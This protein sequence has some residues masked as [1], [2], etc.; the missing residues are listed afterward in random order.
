M[1]KLNVPRRRSVWLRRHAVW[2]FATLALCVGANAN[3]P[4]AATGESAI[5]GKSSRSY[6]QYPTPP[7]TGPSLPAPPIKA[8]KPA[9]P[10]RG[11]CPT[12]S[13][14]A[15][16]NYPTGI[17]PYG[18]VLGHFNADGILDLAVANQ[19]SGTVSIRLG[20]GGGGFGAPASFATEWAP[21]GLVADDFNEDGY[22]DLAT[23]CQ[24][25]ASVSVLFGDGAGGFGSS[26]ILPSGNDPNWITSGDFDNDANVDIAVVVYTGY[27]VVYLGNGAGGFGYA[28][29]YTAGSGA[30][31]LL[32]ADFS[33]DGNLDIVVGNYYASDTVT[34]LPGNGDGT[35]DPPVAFSTGARTSEVAAGFFDADANLDAAVANY[36][37]GNVSILIGNG[38]GS[39]SPAM[40]FPAGAVA[41]WG[42]RA[43]DVNA[44]GILDLV[45][46]NQVS[47]T[48]SVLLGGGDGTFGDA[49]T[50][51]VGYG[52]ASLA[53]GDVN[54][55]GLLDIVTA[56]YRSSSISVLLNTC[57][58]PPCK[59]TCP[60]NVTVS[61]DATEC[62]AVVN[63]PAPFFTGNCGTIACIPPSGSFFP[64]GTTTVMCGE[65][66]ATSGH[67]DVSCSFTVAVNDVQAPAIAC[68][69]NV[70]VP[71]SMV[72][73]C[74]VS[75]TVAFS[76]PAATDNCPGVTTV[77]VPASGTA[78]AEGATQ[79]TCIATDLAGNA[80]TC[81]FT[82]TVDA[83]AAFG[84]C[85]VDDA[86]GDSWSIVTDPAS[87]IYRSWRYRV[88][89][90]GEI[91]CGVA[92]RLAIRPGRTLT[93]ADTIDS[94]FSMSS[95]LNYGSN[96]GIVLVSDVLTGRQFRIR[97]RNLANSDCP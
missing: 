88:A 74:T 2:M 16:M 51:Q 20:T 39:F 30:S 18:V 72:N 95:S 86:T 78:F 29:A 11:G 43:G 9:A 21:S 54:A 46:A 32:A 17:D 31:H 93:A 94:R 7:T 60:A 15:P 36:G 83:A 76:A 28:A 63:Y 67:G 87:G 53:L 79:V 25:D 48:V 85:A 59:I 1:S 40:M 23:A 96:T 68:P 10:P 19:G 89:A 47:T 62:G 66:G 52:P 35:F 13:F 91:L 70:I 77:C 5:A 6:A 61:N 37:S 38:A 8:H 97:D 26:I 42:L 12:P 57:V 22:P 41:P 27:V 82:V 4:L 92:E 56:N 14:G 64:V 65:T 90:T 84:A 81:T 55:D 49:T 24:G 75:A 58:P 73:G 45:T 71:G 80:S 50:L 34:L 44:D 3:G 69:A 33:N